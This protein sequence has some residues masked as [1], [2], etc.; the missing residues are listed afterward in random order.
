MCTAHACD[1]FERIACSGFVGDTVPCGET[2]CEGTQFTPASVCDGKGACKKV[3]AQDCGKFA[4]DKATGCKTTCADNADCAPGS[5]CSAATK[6]CIDTPECA[7]AMETIAANGTKASC[8]AYRC[9]PSTGTCRP[10]CTVS[11]DCAPG[12][13]CNEATKACEELASEGD[14]GCGCTTVGHAS[15]AGAGPLLA[16]LGVCVR[17]RKTRAS[18][19]SR[20][21]CG[22]RT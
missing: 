8:G 19:P 1:G 7:S 2:K 10:I 21:R 6:R 12:K 15:G 5:H 9:D 20:D 16:L 18:M 14:P 11:D 4:C 17:R 3:A 13:A 22:H